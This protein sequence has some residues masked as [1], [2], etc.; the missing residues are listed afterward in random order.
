MAHQRQQIFSNVLRNLQQERCGA[1]R[2]PDSLA[3][4][5]GSLLSTSVTMPPPASRAF[6]AAGGI[7]TFA[8]STT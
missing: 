8:R 4:R 7:V 1:V 6:V 2:V 3:H 5:A